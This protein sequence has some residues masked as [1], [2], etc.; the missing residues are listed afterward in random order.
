MTCQITY[1]SEVFEEKVGVLDR[2]R[3]KSHMSEPN[4]DL[5]LVCEEQVQRVQ[6]QPV[7]K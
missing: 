4:F 3:K 2:R 5:E 6:Q 7:L 1:H